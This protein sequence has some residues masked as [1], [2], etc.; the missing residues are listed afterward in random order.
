MGGTS[1]MLATATANSTTN[2]DRRAALQDSVFVGDGSSANVNTVNYSADAMVL[3][4][5]AN[6]LPDSVKALMGGGATLLR[7]ASA[8]IVDLNKDSIAANSKA[9]DDTLERSA[10]MVDSLIDN[11]SQGYG[12][13]Q[14]VVDSFTP[15]EN[16]NA[17]IVKYAVIA[18]A[19]VALYLLVGN[20]K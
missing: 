2:I 11:M 5:L 15:T 9:W 3:E 8:A 7:D 14:K 6:T 16:K 13:A 10:S 18:A 4:T 12:L 17:E 1:V 19:V 20:K